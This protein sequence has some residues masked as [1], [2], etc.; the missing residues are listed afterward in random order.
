MR[1][2]IME[3]DHLLCGRIAAEPCLV[4]TR[5]R[6]RDTASSRIRS[7]MIVVAGHSQ[8]RAHL[9]TRDVHGGRWDRR[10]RR[11]V[12]RVAVGG[13]TFEAARRCDVGIVASV[14][15]VVGVWRRRVRAA[16]VW[17]VAA[18][19]WG[20]H[21]AVGALGCARRGAGCTSV[22]CGAGSCGQV[23]RARGRALTRVAAVNATRHYGAGATL[24]RSRCSR[25]PSR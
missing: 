4:R 18:S 16:W 12:S 5:S 25:T 17:S 7:G 21:P 10:P 6:A 23:P 13:A 8:V 9:D 3:Q 14:L 22:R 20:R 11:V 24:V 1:P 2:A 15:V 19:V